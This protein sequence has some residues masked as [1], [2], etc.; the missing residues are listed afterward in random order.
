MCRGRGVAATGAGSTF[1]SSSRAFG[2]PLLVLLLG[3]TRLILV[4]DGDCGDDRAVD[5]VEV[6]MSEDEV[7]QIFFV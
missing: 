1:C 7:K 2:I 6:L 5:S 4:A 3:G